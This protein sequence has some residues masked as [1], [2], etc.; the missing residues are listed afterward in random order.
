M[1]RDLAEQPFAGDVVQ[2]PLRCHFP[3]RSTRGS[4]PDRW[5]V[6]ERDAARTSACVVNRAWD[7]A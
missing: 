3:P 5:R 6:G 1:T 2:R 4:H 7:D